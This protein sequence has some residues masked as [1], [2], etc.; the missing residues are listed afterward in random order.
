[1]S[2]DVTL[3]FPKSSDAS[4]LVAAGLKVQ[5]YELHEAMSE[6]FELTLEVLSSDPAIDVAAVVG[7]PIV[8]DFGDEPF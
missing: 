2:L 5:R 3:A 4:A 1:M 7:Q 8:V 6:L